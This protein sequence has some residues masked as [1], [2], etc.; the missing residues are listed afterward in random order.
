MAIPAM[1]GL[2]Q[3]LAGTKNIFVETLGLVL[4]MAAAQ[5]PILPERL[6]GGLPAF[7]SFLFCLGLFLITLPMPF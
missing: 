6:I 5:M 4:Y 3:P 7:L 1:L 2:P